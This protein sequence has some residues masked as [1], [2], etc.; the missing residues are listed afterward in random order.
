[1]TDRSHAADS[2]VRV[3][4]AVAT[5]VHVVALAGLVLVPIRR[6]HELT[7]QVGAPPAAEVEVTLDTAARSAPEEQRAA[8]P[9]TSH[10]SPP[11]VGAAE[12]VTPRSPTASASS[13]PAGA[14][15]AAAG[16]SSSEPTG[17][18]PSGEGP[19]APSGTPGSGEGVVPIPLTASQLGIGRD[20]P[21]MPRSEEKVPTS[22][23]NTPA[24]R[25][26]RGTGLAR[27]RELGLGPEGPA[28]RALADATSSSIAPLRGRAVFL[29]RTGG[30]G[31]VSA[32]DVV[33]SEGGSGWLD[34]GRIALEALR[35]KK[36]NV[37]RGAAGM[38]MRI[39]VRS[40]MKLPS[41]ENAPL[42][43]RLGANGMPE[44]TIP[45][46]ADLGSKP[47]R[48]VHSR[49]VSTELL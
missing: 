3:W 7:P 42:T 5:A 26:M 19:P 38:S 12:R 43:G 31:L 45:D 34:A 48:V 27:D 30:D 1:M 11:T 40:D 15:R 33:D 22:G 36:L 16:M 23:P 32:I 13:A 20:N 28:V 8:Q 6:G 49:V 29:V 47:R 46:V 17:A 10:P 4:I 9:E 41:G 35:G 24:A 39:E 2:R 14:A 25:A 21:F 18:P 37:P 44:M